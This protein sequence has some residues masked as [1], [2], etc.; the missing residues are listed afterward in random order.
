MIYLSVNS[1]KHTKHVIRIKHGDFLEMH[2]ATRALRINE[3]KREKLLNFIL[4]QERNRAISV[5]FLLK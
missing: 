3:H 1:L 5:I 4:F 2:N